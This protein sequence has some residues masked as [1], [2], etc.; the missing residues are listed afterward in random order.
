M[1]S[2][3][4]KLLR[5]SDSFLVTVA[6]EWFVAVRLA[7]EHTFLIG[8]Q[9]VADVCQIATV[10]ADG[11]GLIH[12]FGYR[13]QCGHR[14]EGYPFEVHIQTGDDDAYAAFRQFGADL[15]DTHIEELRFV[16]THDIDIVGKQQDRLAGLHRCGLNNIVIVRY[17]VLLAVAH[18]DGWLEDLYA[19]LGKLRTF[20]PSDE[21]L[22]LTGEHTAA[23]D[24][25]TA[26][27][28]NRTT[29]FSFVEHICELFVIKNRLAGLLMI[30][31]TKVQKNSEI[32]KYMV[33]FLH[34]CTRILQ[35][36]MS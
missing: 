19:L 8:Y 26:T 11:V 14:S 16:N 22:G 13:H 30:T 33:C 18:I 10:H 35:K 34:L 31:G 1:I 27:T 28:Q 36:I 23:Y 3:V 15:Y 20:H 9:T 12:I 7:E 4:V 6:A 21:F 25:N 32:C 5:G 2:A 29:S 24:F 17:D